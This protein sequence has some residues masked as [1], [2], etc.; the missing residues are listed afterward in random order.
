MIKKLK[1]DNDNTYPIDVIGSWAIGAKNAV[2]ACYGFSP[3]HF[4]FGKSASLPSNLVKLPPAVE[5][6][7]HVQ[8]LVKHL[9]ALHTA[10]KLF[11][12]AEP[13]DKLHRALKAKNIET[14]GIEYEIGDMVYYKCKGSHK[15][16]GPGKVIGKEKKQILVKHGGYYIR[17]HLC[18]LQKIST[19]NVDIPEPS[20]KNNNP[21][22]TNKNIDEQLV[23]MNCSITSDDESE[24]YPS[25]KECDTE[26]LPV[27]ENN[28][29]SILT[30]SLN[31]LT[32]CESVNSD[33]SN[34][35]VLNNILAKVRSTVIYGI[36]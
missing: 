23:E 10:R 16:K 9:N 21:D 15:W 24:F 25:S 6:V 20:E 18:S 11:I 7:S 30:D 8:I 34:P 19:N 28:D 4:V 22:D 12:K 36:S 2:Q 17:V 26:N 35:T 3:N 31:D 27:N 13:N 29:A 1:L 14:I 32:I 33:I 5:D